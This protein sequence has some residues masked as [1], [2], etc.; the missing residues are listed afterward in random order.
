MEPGKTKCVAL[1]V[2]LIVIGL[3]MVPASTQVVY[4]CGGGY[5]GSIVPVP[6]CNPPMSFFVEAYGLLLGGVALVAIG[7]TFLLIGSRVGKD[8]RARI[9][10]QV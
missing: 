9:S 7:I 5:L 6:S 10:T 4:K 2:I 8:S 1:G 3:V